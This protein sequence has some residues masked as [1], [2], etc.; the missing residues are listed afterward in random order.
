MAN[1]TEAVSATTI[2]CFIFII[3]LCH[4]GRGADYDCCQ[5]RVKMISKYIAIYVNIKTE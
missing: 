5:T 4:L 3:V 1:Y 2:D